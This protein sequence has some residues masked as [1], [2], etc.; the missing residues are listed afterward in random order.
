MRADEAEK[1]AQRA[2]LNT[3]YKI[4]KKLRGKSSQIQPVKDT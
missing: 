3:V 2:D 4:R 1:G